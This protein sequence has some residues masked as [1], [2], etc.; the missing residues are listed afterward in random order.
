MVAIA[1]TINHP[2]TLA[3]LFQASAMPTNDLWDP[4]LMTKVLED[5]KSRK[6][7]L[8][9]SAYMIRAESNRTKHWYPW[10]KNRYIS[11]IVIGRLWKRKEEF[12]SK[13]EREGLTLEEAWGFLNNDPNLVGWGP[14]MSYEVITDLRHTR[15]LLNAP[16]R[17]TWANAGPGA[18]RG[19]NRIFDRPLKQKVKDPCAEMNA[20][21]L[22]LNQEFWPKGK[23]WGELE[24]RDVEHSLCEFD[25]YERA[26]L[27][28]GRPREK[29]FM[30]SKRP[31]EKEERNERG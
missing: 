3:E 10:P 18:L 19:L 24:M 8:Y 4:S 22:C 1:R 30:F 2:P 21:L 9:T 17:M 7:K 29:F 6:E 16:D 27:G 25:K 13:F 20:I 26:R 11:E 28:E 14:F 23:D 15:Y 12:A 5:R 31:L